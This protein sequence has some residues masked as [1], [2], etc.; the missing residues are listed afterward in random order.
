MANLST[1]ILEIYDLEVLKPELGKCVVRD[2]L[3]SGLEKALKRVTPSK[4]FAAQT[5]DKE[6]IYN[7][8][9][10][11][12]NTEVL[13]P[14]LGK[15]RVK[16]ALYGGLG[17]VINMLI[18][19][20]VSGVD[21]A[22]LDKEIDFN[23]EEFGNGRQHLRNAFKKADIITY[24]DLIEH[25]NKYASDCKRKGYKFYKSEIWGGGPR[26][27]K[28]LIRRDA[29]GI[30][31]LNKSL[32]YLYGHLDLLGINLFSDG[33]RKEEVGH[34]YRSGFKHVCEL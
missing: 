28:F 18:P 20:E 12:Y 11:I 4:V 1:K 5:V 21:E 31:G 32:V 23:A 13:T 24:G 22:L 33:Y 6:E 25:V 7:E 2:E 29:I 8:I 17:K 15:C 19:S 10:S 9:M 34:L 14:E 27:E 30:K 26:G 16:E 3:A